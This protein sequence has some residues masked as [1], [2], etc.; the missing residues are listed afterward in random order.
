MAVYDKIE[1]LASTLTHGG[2][3]QDF[4]IQIVLPYASAYYSLAVDVI[5]PLF[6]I[7]LSVVLILYFIAPEYAFKKFV[8]SF[9][10]AVILLIP[11]EY[12]SGDTA[13]WFSSPTPED[14]SSVTGIS[15]GEE[16]RYPKSVVI[17]FGVVGF[18]E[19]T[20]YEGINTISA[21][22]DSALAQG[23]LPARIR[24]IASDATSAS[25]LSP[26]LMALHR[27]YRGACLQR[28]IEEEGLTNRELQSVGL[29]SA[30]MPGYQT[31]QYVASVDFAGT[32]LP[33][34]N[35]SGTSARNSGTTDQSETASKLARIKA[36][37]SSDSYLN[38][39]GS[40]VPSSSWYVDKPGADSIQSGQY[41]RYY[42]QASER[43]RPV[44]GSSVSNSVVNPF[45]FYAQDCEELFQMVKMANQQYFRYLARTEEDNIST[46]DEG[47]SAWISRI[48]TSSPGQRQE[49]VSVQAA[50]LANIA[51]ARDISV[52]KEA[53]ATGADYG[54]RGDSGPISIGA[55][56]NLDAAFKGV[57]FELMDF[58]K[59]WHLDMAAPVAMGTV[60]LGIGLLFL[61]L[62]LLIAFSILPGNIGMLTNAIKLVF[63]GKLTLL[64]MYLTLR[65]GLLVSMAAQFGVDIN[66]GIPAN[67]ITSMV[68]IAITS[69]LVTFSVALTVAPALAYLIVFS[70]SKGLSSLQ[71]GSLGSSAIRANIIAGAAAL[72]TVASAGR[73]GKVVG[74]LGKTA[75]SS[76]GVGRNRGRGAGVPRK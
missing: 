23:V 21:G 67:T 73:M 46:D 54:G 59:K 28:A 65:L 36:S 7:G 13:L 69:E 56:G 42:L 38:P 72:K 45:L 20:L 12:Q 17:F 27:T 47:V 6:L 8:A 50:S 41:S 49:E 4:V 32:G 52:Y 76:G 22:P 34:K 9:A 19:S 44:P 26:D 75:S 57:G 18:L 60:A 10:L 51:Y 53:A 33:V 16:Y 48:F 35:F 31:G 71:P 55:T 39:A 11:G 3:A 1:G 25:T 5:Q 63:F 37:A 30:L 2:A 24:K 70:E 15:A 68:S 29:M 40:R 43:F 64:M 58:W 62:P 74:G 66:Q 14:I 61:F